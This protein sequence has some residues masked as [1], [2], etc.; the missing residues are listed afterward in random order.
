MIAVSNANT[1]EVEQN[2]PKKLSKNGVRK[3]LVQMYML[4]MIC[5]VW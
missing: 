4:M 1:N 2:N 3:M 5:R